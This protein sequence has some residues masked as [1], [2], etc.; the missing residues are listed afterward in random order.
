MMIIPRGGFSKSVAVTPFGPSHSSYVCSCE[1][2]FLALAVTCTLHSMRYRHCGSCPPRP[3]H[4]PYAK[5][6][7]LK[8]RSCNPLRLAVLRRTGALTVVGRSWLRNRAFSF[9]DSKPWLN[10][11]IGLL[12]CISVLQAGWVDFTL[13]G[14]EGSN[15]FVFASNF[16]DLL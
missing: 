14:P 5:S 10:C 9:Y 4:R 6:A 16:W 12:H 8:R 3:V 13:Q 1:I 11:G 15:L 2:A 7:A